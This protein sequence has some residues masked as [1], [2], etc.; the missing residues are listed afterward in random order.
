MSKSVQIPQELW[1]DLCSY[2]LHPS[3][4]ADFEADLW[5]RIRDRL[6]A[7]LDALI[8][9]DLYSRYRR[10]PTAEEREH[11]RVAYLDAV[12]VPASFRSPTPPDIFT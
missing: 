1:E 12:G 5:D 10:A 6:D 9:H 11:A 7:K 3:P 4:D 8:R 2:F